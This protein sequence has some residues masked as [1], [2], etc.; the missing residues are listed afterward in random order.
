M[1]EQ[2]RIKKDPKMQKTTHPARFST[3][4]SMLAPVFASVLCSTAS[5]GSSMNAP[6]VP[7]STALPV[8]AES[9]RAG[10]E[11]QVFLSPFLP[12]AKPSVRIQGA[13]EVDF[14]PE[15]VEMIPMQGVFDLVQFP[16]PDGTVLCL[17]EGKADIFC[18]RFN[19]EWITAP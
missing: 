7:T 16:L 11:R 13:I 8:A 6:V 3:L 9:A 15:L 10:D 2:S 17:Y 19:L 12:A 14:L 5:F 1:K 18:A 4:V